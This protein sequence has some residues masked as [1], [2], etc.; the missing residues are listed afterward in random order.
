VASIRELLAGY[1]RLLSGAGSTVPRPT[2]GRP[3]PAD[4]TLDA[5][6]F[7]STEALHEFERAVSRLPGVREVVL[8][9]YQ[10]TDRALLEVRLDHPST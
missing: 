6:P 5:G 2:R 1:D 3:D 7:A 4:A 10:G 9:A 8:R